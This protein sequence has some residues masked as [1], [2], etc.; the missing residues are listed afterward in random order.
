MPTIERPEQKPQAEAS[1]ESAYVTKW[2]ARIKR[3]EKKMQ[4]AGGG[5]D[6]DREWAKSIKFY[7]GDQW[8]APDK[9]SK[10]RF[11]RVTS[12]Q[13]KANIDCIRPQLYFQNPKVRIQVKN[14]SITPVPIPETQMGPGMFG[15]PTPQPVMDPA[16]GQPKVAVPA[17]GA[18]AM[19][20][21]LPVNAREQCE[22]LESIDN[23]YLEETGAKLKFRRVI[24]D[25]L[26]LPYGVSK[27]EW[28]VELG[29]EE[30]EVVDRD[31]GDIK[32]EKVEVVKREYPWVTRIQP[33]KFLWDPDLEEFDID[34]AKWVAEIKL[35]SREEIE[36]DL[37]LDVDLDQIPASETY[38][39]EGEDEQDQ[40]ED[41]KRFK[42]YEIHDLKNKE[43]LVLVQGAKKPARRESPSMYNMVEGSIYTVLGF[44]EAPDSAFPLALPEQIKSKVQAY[45]WVLSYQVNHIQRFNR[46]Y[47]MLRGVA[48]PAENEKLE[49]GADG[50]IVHVD[51]MAG[52]PEPIPDGTISPDVY[53]V[54]NILKREITEDVG[55]TAYDR[56]T[57]ETGVD[58]AYEAGLVQGGSDIKIQ[59]KRDIV[60]EFVK[61]NVRKL[62]QL[63]KEFATTEQVMEIVG[64]K[65]SRWVSWTNKDIQ[66]EFLEDVDVYNA[67][68][69]ARET[70][71][72][73]AMEL[74][75]IAN[76]N[77]Y[78]NQTRLWERVFRAFEWGNELLATPEE[79]AQQQQQQAQQ[80]QME[81]QKRQMGA[82]ARPEGGPRG[83][84][85]VQ[86]AIMG[87]SNKPRQ[88]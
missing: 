22:L 78:V 23:Y 61:K 68:P 82:V 62:N 9:G 71:K 11:H 84:N 80:Q 19:V 63:L 77:P 74:V 38:T 17:G 5:I 75:A 2:T 8:T 41:K 16:T 87:G 86:G 56:G 26:V 48:D 36:S 55:V 51:S 44:D 20:G 57:R 53:N 42:V 43:F 45:N 67:L 60:L 47:K 72:K 35:L 24:N 18:V 30:K 64:P 32:I 29:E 31:T 13:V 76:M 65:G 4:D 83:P 1:N 10:G 81:E 59:E 54:G 79:M 52:G 14:P 12:N 66:G 50:T 21:G 69:Y 37:R 73:Q 88:G 39:L 49:L 3:A 40:D 33:W 85:A 6:A 34:Q 58:T 46:K 15:Q 25:A 27:W 7:R 70:E 28:I